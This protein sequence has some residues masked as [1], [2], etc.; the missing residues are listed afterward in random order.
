MFNMKNQFKSVL[1][2]F[3][4]VLV[5]G[6]ISNTALGYVTPTATYSSSNVTPTATYSSNYVTP[7]ATY[8]S[9]Y[10]TPTATYSSS[11]ITPTASYSSDWLSCGASYCGSS[12]SYTPTYA[13]TY[14]PTYSYSCTSQ[15]SV[16][17]QR[18]CLGN[19]YQECYRSSD[20]CLYWGGTTSCGSNQ[21]CNN[22]SCI[23]HETCSNECSTFGQRRCSGNGYQVCGNYDSDSCLE[24]DG[25]INCGYNQT[26]NN[27]S[28]TDSCANEYCGNGICNSNCGETKLSCSQDCGHINICSDILSGSPTNQEQTECTNAGGHILCGNGWCRCNCT[29]EQ[30]TVDLRSS[31]SANCNQ[32]ATL[33]WS[34]NNATSCYA[35]GSWSG[36][37][38][39]SGSESV[40]N[41]TGSRTYTLTCS[42]SN[43]SASDTVTLNG[44]GD[45]LNVDAGS[46][47]DIDSG[48]SVRLDGSVD[49]DYDSV[50]WSCTGGSLSD[51][52]ILRPTYYAPPYNDYNY[53]NNRTYTCT[54]TARN[55][56]GSDSDSMR[57][58]IEGQ[59]SDFNVA[60]IA[61][62]KSD[63]APM[64]NVDLI[65]TLS[66]YGSNYNYNYTYY[67][68]CEND[69]DWD[70]TIT[71]SETSYTA[72]DLCDYRNVGS[73]TARVR[74]ESRNRTAT[75]TEIVRADECNHQ[76]ENGRVNIQKWVKNISTG[77]AYQKS[78][79]ANPGN[80][81][82]YK[83]A[84]TALSG[85]SSNITVRD[86]MPSG[87]SNLRDLQIEGDGSYHGG[88]IESG[89]DIG[90]LD[91]GDV[92]N[93]TFTGTVN[94]IDNFSYG[95]TAITNVAT[96]DVNGNTA[97][98]RATVYVYRYAVKG[99]T[100][101]STGF[102]NNTFA[103]LG[104][105]FVAITAT[106]IWILKLRKKN[107][108]KIV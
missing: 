52:D 101:V 65:A 16:V 79:T 55:N 86:I 62:P 40:G 33:S 90:S 54:L 36:N 27:G 44:G 19:G 67:F 60:L 47:Q 59:S 88:N 11:Y 107:T 94:G 108:N 73:Y 75:D 29:Q 5:F 58:A 17:G 70:R 106:A 102:D 96:I 66:N 82:S 32:N 1:T 48:D 14:T 39:L 35:S 45:S 24:W 92:K 64:N 3:A 91:Q 38:S 56:C 12:Y 81:V 18:R 69:G 100:I 4:I 42:N 41:F 61:R 28:C 2:I 23:Y 98:D 83:I 25:T 99:A 95:Q 97:S 34:S 31:G 22:G 51:Y 77:T 104:L 74:V 46:D 105:L 80:I 87:I 93:I 53:N 10:V 85:D 8:S 57:I 103:G 13:Y 6:F 71:T 68:D 76:E 72:T 21:T 20:N 37:K 84:I 78:T 50:S 49:G 89:I 9:G 7:T 43:S 63:C 26:C 30:P 15:C